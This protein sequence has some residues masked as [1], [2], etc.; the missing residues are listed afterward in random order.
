MEERQD[1]G[2]EYILI[3]GL[4]L[5]VIK[6]YINSSRIIISFSSRGEEPWAG[7]PINKSTEPR[8]ECLTVV[9]INLFEKLKYREYCHESEV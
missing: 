3:Y 6:I 7:E 8:L 2:T 1:M 4:K 9:G 5:H